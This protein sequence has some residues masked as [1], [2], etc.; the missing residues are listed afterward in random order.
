MDWVLLTVGSLIVLFCLIQM[1]TWTAVQFRRRDAER[2]YWQLQSRLLTTKIE[3]IRSQKLAT[4]QVAQSAVKDQKTESSD[5]SAAWSGWR[6]FRVKRLARETDNTSSVT[7]EPSDGM[8]LPAYRPGQFLTLRLTLPGHSKPVI[9]CYSLSDAPGTQAY[10]ITVKDIH[11][12]MPESGGVSHFINWQ[13]TAGA[14]VEL[15]APSGDFYLDVERKTPVILLAGGVGITPL[16]SMI[17]TVLKQGGR[18]DLL[19]FYGLR[20]QERSGAHFQG[21]DQGPGGTIPKFQ[22][23]G[24]LF[25]PRAD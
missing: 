22:L 18:R 23:S 14:E 8:D 20:S 3:T 25:Q 6:K 1:A 15:K 17:E 21:A 12:R 16:M 10:R 11:G 13:W 19:L 5:R 4:A 2:E 9:R 24:L 7:L